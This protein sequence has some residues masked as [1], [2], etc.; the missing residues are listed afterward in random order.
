MTIN[1]RGVSR[2]HEGLVKATGP[3]AT[4]YSCAKCGKLLHKAPQGR[5]SYADL[6]IAR[7]LLTKH[8]CKEAKHDDHRV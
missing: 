6:S 4:V 1:Q 2:E 7:G 8:I 5:R 3:I